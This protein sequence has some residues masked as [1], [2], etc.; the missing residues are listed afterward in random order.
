[1]H[2][3]LAIRALRVLAAVLLLA[4]A[5]VAAARGAAS[6][7]TCVSRT[8]AQPPSLPVSDSLHGVAVL[9]PCNAW[10]VGAYN[11][12]AG[13]ATLIEHWNGTR[14]HIVASRNP[15][16]SSNYLAD[17]AAASSRNVWAVGNDTVLGVSKSLIEHWTGSGWKVVKSPDPGPAHDASL[18]GVAVFIG[19][20]WAV[21]S[22]NAGTVTRTF[23]VRWNGRAWR[24]VASPNAGSGSNQLESVVTLSRWASTPPRTGPARWPCIAVDR[25]GCPC[26]GGAGRQL[27]QIARRKAL[28]G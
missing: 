20:A 18:S 1:M 19:G 12:G 25:A 13:S 5:L 22:Y 15:S 28:V 6:A 27:P 7:A 16:L 9:S 2:A 4:G 11:N 10:A 14:W 17:V 23:I 26:S 24:K 3:R 21:G 8:G